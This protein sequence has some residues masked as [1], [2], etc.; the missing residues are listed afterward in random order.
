MMLCLSGYG[1]RIALQAEI[2]SRF[3]PLLPSGGKSEIAGRGVGL[4]YAA[5]ATAIDARL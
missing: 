1:V 3:S 2:H 5:I 4:S